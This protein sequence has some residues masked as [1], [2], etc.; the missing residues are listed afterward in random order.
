MKK[1]KWCLPPEWI[2][3]FETDIDGW[4]KA[5]GAWTKEKDADEMIITVMRKKKSKWIKTEHRFTDERA[6]YLAHS[7]EQI[8]GVP[9]KA[10]DA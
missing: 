3:T 1:I 6:D 4:K 5:D 7:M 9:H 8:T 10:V 2:P